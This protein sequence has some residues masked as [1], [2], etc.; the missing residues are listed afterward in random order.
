MPAICVSGG[1]LISFGVISLAL[2][3]RGRSGNHA[4]FAQALVRNHLR[5]REDLQDDLS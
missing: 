2:A 4:Q 3:R 1:V 5:D